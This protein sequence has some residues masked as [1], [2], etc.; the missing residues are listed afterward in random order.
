MAD[1]EAHAACPRCSLSPCGCRSSLSV[2]AA[3]LLVRTHSAGLGGG[4]SLTPAPPR[5]GDLPRPRLSELVK[6]LIVHDAE[7]SVVPPTL[8]DGGKLFDVVVRSVLDI[9]GYG[10]EVQR[11]VAFPR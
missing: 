9:A 7:N 8:T 10:D 3:P 5:G 1:F 4:P 6:V 2:P 11:G